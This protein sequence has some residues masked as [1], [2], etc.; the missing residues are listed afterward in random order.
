MARF[1]GEVGYGKSVEDPPAS[2]IWVDGIIER[3]YQGDVVRN[4]RTLESGEKVN[5]DL[6]IGNSISIVADDYAIKHFYLIKYVRWSGVLWTVR[7][8]EV[9]HPRLILTLGGVYNGPTP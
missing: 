2:G 1:H 9:Q 8:V 6:T 7:T 4:S 5:D 3:Q